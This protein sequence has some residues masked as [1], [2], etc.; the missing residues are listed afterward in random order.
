MSK[1]KKIQ[2]HLEPTWPFL[3]PISKLFVEK[4]WEERGQTQP[5]GPAL[6]SPCWVWKGQF[7]AVPSG[8]D[9]TGVMLP[10]SIQET[11]GSA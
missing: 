11:E 3:F 9:G 7:Q 4:W 8:A 10:K 1:K 6:A 5:W 2:K